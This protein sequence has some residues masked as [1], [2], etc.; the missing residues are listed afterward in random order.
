MNNKNKY[1][2]SGAPDQKRIDVYAKAMS[3]IRE[4]T[5]VSDINEVI[6]K[7]A[8][9][10]E[11]FENLQDLKQSNEKKLMNITDKRMQVKDDLEKMKLEGLEAM[12]RKQVEDMEQAQI[13]SEVNH[14]KTTEKIKVTQKTTLEL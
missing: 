3:Q 14:R 6:H 9:Q 8:T 4:A 1:S 5:G 7:F 11:T 13:D 10:A 12:T 2:Y